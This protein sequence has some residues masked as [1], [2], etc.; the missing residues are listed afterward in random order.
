MVPDLSGKGKALTC[1]SAGHRNSLK[2][3][4]RSYHTD[5]LRCYVCH[6]VLTSTCFMKE[7]TLYCKDHFYKRFGTKCTRC[8]DGIIPDSAVRKASGHVYHVAC[9]QCVICKRELKTGEEFYLIPDDGRLVC[10]NDYEL[11]RDKRESTKLSE[12]I[13]CSKQ[14]RHLPHESSSCTISTCFAR[15]AVSCAD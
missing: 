14:G 13:T 1:S 10:K 2:N 9:F 5:C 3:I 8:G 6:E 4:Y 15:E 11:A 12:S 7:D